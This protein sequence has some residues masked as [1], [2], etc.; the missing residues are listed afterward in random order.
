MKNF[1]LEINLHRNKLQMT[2]I[3]YVEWQGSHHH[4]WAGNELCVLG[5]S[6]S[7]V[8]SLEWSG[9]RERQVEGGWIQGGGTLV[10]WSGQTLQ[11]PE[12]LV[13]DAM[14]G[15]QRA[16]AKTSPVLSLSNRDNY[17]THD[18]EENP[19]GRVGLTDG[20]ELCFRRAAREVTADIWGDTFSWWQRNRR[21]EF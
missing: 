21:L 17:G 19:V 4:Q 20:L 5:G 8:C 3:G 1:S 13:M 6:I 14:R 2:Q 18:K 12:S 16:E 7:I 10:G 15:W 9:E 11:R